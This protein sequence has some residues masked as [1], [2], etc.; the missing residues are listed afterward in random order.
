VDDVAGPQTF[1]VLIANER[2][3]RLDRVSE[4]VRRAGHHV[5]ARAISIAGVAEAAA[6]VDPDVAIVAA[7]E[8]DEH[9]I[10]LIERLVEEASCPVI[11]HVERDE[12]DVVR[13]AARH[14]IYG[15]V[16]D[17]DA[18][19]LEGSIEIA[20]RRYA[21]LRDLESAFHRRALVERAKGVLMERHAI[22]ERAAF[23]LLRDHARAR[24][25][26]VVTVAKALLDGHPLLPS[27]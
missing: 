1:S 7:G 2:H 23:A 6:E 3:D 16:F 15:M 14:G 5:T 9:A 21:D 24:Q 18:A 25:E 27:R 13:E 17:G 26:R 4:I 20:L 22:D 10:E 19:G 12:T 8:S 11:L